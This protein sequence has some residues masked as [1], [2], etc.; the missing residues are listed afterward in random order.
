[1]AAAAKKPELITTLNN[2]FSLTGATQPSG[3]Q[4]E[5]DESVSSWI[6]PFIMASINTKNIHRSNLL[7]SHQYGKGF[8]YDEMMMTGPGDGHD[9]DN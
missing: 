8:I 1:M 7:L 2:V 3:M 4:V 9:A 6:A 5:Y